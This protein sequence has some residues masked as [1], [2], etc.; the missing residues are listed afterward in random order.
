MDTTILVLLFFAVILA[1]VKKELYKDFG[2][3]SNE[4]KTSLKK[5]F[6]KSNVNAAILGLIFLLI[7]PILFSFLQL[8][9]IFI[10]VSICVL[11]LMLSLEAVY[12]LRRIVIY[13]ISRKSRIL[14]LLYKFTTILIY[15][16]VFYF[17]YTKI[18]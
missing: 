11:I 16:W 2:K 12:N 8:G 14:F 4:D 7:L 17:F 3:S 15:L 6:M 13:P 10:Y 9:T 18:M 1:V 5:V